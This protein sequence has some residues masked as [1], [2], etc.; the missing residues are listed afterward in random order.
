[1]IMIITVT[2][3]QVR[4]PREARQKAAEPRPIADRIAATHDMKHQKQN[5][6]LRHSPTPSDQGTSPGIADSR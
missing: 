2:Y 6:S 1:M 4:Q 3:R 5:T